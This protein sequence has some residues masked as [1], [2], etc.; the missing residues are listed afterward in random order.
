MKRRKA[1]VTQTSSAQLHVAS[2][3]ALSNLTKNCDSTCICSR[4]FGQVSWSSMSEQDLPDDLIYCINAIPTPSCRNSLSVLALAHR[5]LWHDLVATIASCTKPPRLTR[6]V[7]VSN[8]VQLGQAGTQQ[9][10]AKSRKIVT[11]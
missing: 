6:H 8:G 2:I 9:S 5:V 4:A 10:E 3:Q 1:L 11:L 7:L